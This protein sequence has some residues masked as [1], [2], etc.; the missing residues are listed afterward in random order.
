MD[1]YEKLL[2]IGQKPYL[3]IPDLNLRQLWLEKFDC[4]YYITFSKFSKVIIDEIMK[5]WEDI[6]SKENKYDYSKKRKILRQAIEF[7][8]NFPKSE[9]I[10]PYNLYLL[11][12]HWGSLENIG[13]NIMRHCINNYGFLGFLNSQE[14]QYIMKEQLTNHN[15][16]QSR[17]VEKVNY[18][19]RFSRLSPSLLTITFGYFV[20]KGLLNCMHYRKPADKEIDEFIPDIMNQFFGKKITSSKP[21]YTNYTR[22]VSRKNSYYGPFDKKMNFVM[23][24]QMEGCSGYY[25]LSNDDLY[26]KDE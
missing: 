6:E 1:M 26:Q 10:T 2:E 24:H 22:E 18:I 5:K 11:I 8:T 12:S 19:I 4:N 3:L 20:E 15:T 25:T 7:F 14:G 21:I 16:K 9:Y 23:L 13:K 17:D